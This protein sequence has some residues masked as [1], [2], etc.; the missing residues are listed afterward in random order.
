MVESFRDSGIPGS[1]LALALE[2]ECPDEGKSVKQEYSDKNN[3]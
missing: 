2:S 3:Q 1:G